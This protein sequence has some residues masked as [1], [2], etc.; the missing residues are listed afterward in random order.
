MPTAIMPLVSPMPS[1]PVTAI[2]STIAGNDRK[3]S[4]I[5]A[6]DVVD[7]AAEEAGDEADR[8]ADRDADA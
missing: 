8:H 3:V 7:P 1:A 4:M 2:A 6:D 5:A